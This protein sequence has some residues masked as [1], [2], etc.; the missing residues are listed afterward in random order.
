MT[1]VVLLMICDVIVLRS[2]LTTFVLKQT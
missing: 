1:Y 2:L